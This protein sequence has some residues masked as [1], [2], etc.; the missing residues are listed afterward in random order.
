MVKRDRIRRLWFGTVAA[1]MWQT[2]ASGQAIGFDPD[3]LVLQC[4]LGPCKPTI[5][6]LTNDMR[7]S[8]LSEE[9]I[10]EQIGVMAAILLDSGIGQTD[11]ITTHVADALT[12]LSDIST[13]S[14]QRDALQDVATE[15]SAGELDQFATTAPVAASRDRPRNRF[16]NGFR[17]RFNPNRRSRFWDIF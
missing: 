3:V 6:G 8:G 5:E 4:Q 1:M 10:N 11:Q 7:N 15:L 17:R 16:R 2:P 12:A 14:N 13:N 9:E